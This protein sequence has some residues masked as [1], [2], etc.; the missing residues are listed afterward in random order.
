M[1]EARRKASVLSFLSVSSILS[2]PDVC[3]FLALFF[4]V[5]FGAGSWRPCNAAS[6][7]EGKQECSTAAIYLSC[8]FV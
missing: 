5:L 3:F 1:R 6:Y 8:I 7:G 2:W 4:F